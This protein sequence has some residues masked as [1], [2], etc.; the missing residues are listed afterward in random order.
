MSKTSEVEHIVA[1]MARREVKKPSLSLTQQYLEGLEV[2]FEGTEPK[3]QRIALDQES[4]R[5]EVYFPIKNE[6]F[7]LVICVNTAPLVQIGWTYIQPGNSVYFAASSDDLTFEE[8]QRITTLRATDGGT[9][10]QLRKNSPDD[11]FR[12]KFSHFTFEPIPERAYDMEEK[13]LQLLDKLETD[14]QGVQK[15]AKIADAGI[16]VCQYDYAGFGSINGV[17]LDKS[18]IQRLA[19]L[20]LDIDFDLYASGD[21][22]K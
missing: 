21:S 11:K 14:T 13:L 15:L 16:N 3:I 22:I 5:F 8:L 10:G 19:H 20:G 17:S 12:Y 18:T 2:V 4:N 9:K 7:F 6:R 1:Y